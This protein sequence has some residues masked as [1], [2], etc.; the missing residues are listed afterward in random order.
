MLA[1]QHRRWTVDLSRWYRR[2]TSWC[3]PDWL[4]WRWRKGEEGCIKTLHTAG[5]WSVRRPNKMV[6]F[7]KF[8]QT[9]HKLLNKSQALS[10]DLFQ[11]ISH[12]SSKYGH[13]IPK[14]WHFVQNLYWPVV[15]LPCGKHFK[16]MEKFCKIA[17]FNTIDQ[18]SLFFHEINQLFLI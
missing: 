9:F 7:L 15:C 4:I 18:Q 17:L 2:R 5:R 11:C 3:H 12:G 16:I 6:S 10:L 1:L 14:C 13:E 8:S